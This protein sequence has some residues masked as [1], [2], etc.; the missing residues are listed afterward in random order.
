M[1]ASNVVMDRPGRVKDY[2]RHVLRFH[3]PEGPSRSAGTQCCELEA[4][5]QLGEC[6]VETHLRCM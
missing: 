3:F 5:V 2:E 1:N 6:R 4:D